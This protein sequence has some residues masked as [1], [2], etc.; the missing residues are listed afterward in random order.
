[1]LRKSL[2]ATVVLAA[3][4]VPGAA[5][6][7]NSD[8]VVV[9]G[10][11][12]ATSELAITD[13]EQKAVTPSCTGGVVYDDGSLSSG[14]ALSSSGQ[15]AGAVTR[16]DLPVG[17]TG[18]DQ[19][20]VCFSR[21]AAAPSGISFDLV[22]Y[23]NNG[24]GGGP[25]TLIAQKPLSTSSI[26]ISPTFF[27]FN[28]TGQSFSLPDNVVYIG[29]LWPSIFGSEA[30]FIC[31]DTSSGLT[32][33]S[34]YFS[35]TNGAS[36]GSYASFFPTGTSNPRTFGIRVDP[37][38]P[39][40]GGCTPSSTAICLNN[41]RFKVQATF[42]TATQ[43]TTSAIPVKLTDDSGYL[44]FFN[45]NNIELVVK[46]LNACG[47]NNRYWVFA[48]GL[49]NVRVDITVTDTQTGAT[50]TYPNFLNTPFPPLQDTNAF[51]T[52]P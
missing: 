52:C 41:N 34:N 3:L 30:V 40:T 9:D 45:S 18:L 33:R 38:V 27:N 6:E 47:V 24:A 10:E 4:S 28:L 25:G 2:L 7:V 42:A 13:D 26:S 8:L 49:T 35:S 17:T 44:W 51:A 31:G 48:A 36:W 5:Q 29:V 16:F 14:Y 21:S 20:C 11:A 15:R 1:M 22:V 50:K 19:L 37:R 39:V 46:V 12:V 43:G 32:Q 23:D